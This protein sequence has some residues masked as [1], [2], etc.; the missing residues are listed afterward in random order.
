MFEP[1]RR[2]FAGKPDMPHARMPAGERAYVIGDIHG[3]NDLFVQLISAIEAD[4]AV[5]PEARTTIVLLGDLIDRGPDSAGVVRTARKVMKRA[6]LR[7]LMGNHEE[8]FLES[9]DDTKV[10]RHF[11]RH[12]GRET[13]ISYG[14]S[15]EQFGHADIK[16]LQA[17]MNQ[18]VPPKHR[19]FLAA[20][21]DMI[22][23]G[24]YLFVHAG[25][26]PDRPLSD[27]RP[28]ALRWIREPFLDHRES[29]SHVVVHGHTISENID[30]RTNRI[31]IDTGAY[32]NGCLT[33]LVLEGDARRYIQAVEGKN[34]IEIVTRSAA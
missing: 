33:A 5:A 15:P 2:M 28:S 16:R 8:M 10:L 25:I 13:L 27:Q 22:V 1:L 23:M 32:R 26:D 20:F 11:L 19:D 6:D 29:H 17:L 30:E 7:C 14:V 31:G 34:S 12:G 18:L 21:E 9:F 3:R 24:D 4:D